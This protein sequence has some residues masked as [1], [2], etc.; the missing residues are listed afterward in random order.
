M[1]AEQRVLIRGHI[2]VLQDLACLQQHT[3]THTESSRESPTLLTG[4]LSF[5][6]FN[7]QGWDL[8]GL[9]SSILR[10]GDREGQKRKC[11]MG[12]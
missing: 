10:E 1:F 4:R 6:G 2:F 7:Q 8:G 11:C 9:S 12:G 5:S 3:N